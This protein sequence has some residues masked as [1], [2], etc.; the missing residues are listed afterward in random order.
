MNKVLI[1][2]A[3][4]F[5]SLCS[6]VSAQTASTTGNDE[7]YRVY[8]AVFRTMYAGDKVTF[9]LHSTVKQLV[10]RTETTIEYATAEKKENWPQVKIRL[11]NLSDETI[12]NYETSLK[13]SSTLKRSFDLSLKY[14]LVPK[15][16][17]DL[18][19]DAGSHY[20]RMAN[21][22]TKFYERFPDSGGHIQIS[23]VGFS[24][25]RDQALV[26]FIHWCGTLCGTGHYILLNKKDK[27]WNVEAIAMIW[28]S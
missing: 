4:A 5:L 28:I 15:R 12:A 17:F 25:C 18:I 23:N 13:P 20:D 8:N 27:V 2:F 6:F 7:T 24:K 26:Y 16:D 1:F 3:L 21:N 14:S 11:P 9:D 22:W 10:I 19:F